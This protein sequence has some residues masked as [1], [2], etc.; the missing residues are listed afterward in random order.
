MSGSKYARRVRATFICGGDMTERSDITSKCP[1]RDEHT[2]SPTGYSDW[3]EW[4]ARKAKTHRQ[5]R[6]QPCGLF[7]VWLPR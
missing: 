2:P 5:V 3:F 7:A 1:K 4:A 6:H